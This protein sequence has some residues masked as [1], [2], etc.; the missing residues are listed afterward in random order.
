M[1]GVPAQAASFAFGIFLGVFFFGGLWWTVR[2]ALAS[3]RPAVWILTSWI[4]RTSLVLSGFYLMAH[5]D[6]Q[7]IL[8][9]L[10]GFIAGRV[11][12][13]RRTRLGSEPIPILVPKDR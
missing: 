4:V 6:W 2:R 3:K 8:L 10:I 9:C 11:A 7:R 5:G 1:I 12:V 13:S